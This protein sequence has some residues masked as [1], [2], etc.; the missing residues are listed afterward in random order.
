MADLHESLIVSFRRVLLRKRFTFVKSPMPTY[1]PD[2]L[3]E[4]MRDG[5]RIQIVVEAEI[6]STLFTDHTMHQ[7]VVMSE[8]IEHQRRKKIAVKGYLLVPPGKSLL[9]QANGLLE[10]LFPENCEIV[11]CQRYSN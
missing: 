6:L 3:A 4:K 8:F 7:L 10:A 11:A 9:S 2:I 5:R 1:R